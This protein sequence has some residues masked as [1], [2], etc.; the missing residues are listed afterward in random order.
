MV[1]CHALLQP[2]PASSPEGCEET[3]S[4]CNLKKLELV[5]QPKQTQ[6]YSLVHL[7]ME[8]ETY[9]EEQLKFEQNTC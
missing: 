5:T 6:D 7:Q 8:M 9:G 1:L 3:S 4:L 2:P